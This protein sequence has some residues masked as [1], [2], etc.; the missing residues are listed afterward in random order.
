MENDVQIIQQSAAD[1]AALPRSQARGGAVVYAVQE[2]LARDPT[3][4]RWHSK[5]DLA[6]VVTFG[7]LVFVLPQ[8]HELPNDPN[9]LAKLLR[10]KLSGMTPTDYFLPVGSPALIALAGAIAADVTEGRLQILT[11][12]RGRYSVLAIDDV[13]GEDEDG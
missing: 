4:G 5:F 10:D 7:E 6:P 3:S 8:R 2:P 9:E 13:F 1:E 12:S 11:F